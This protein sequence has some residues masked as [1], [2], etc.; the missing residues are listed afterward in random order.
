MSGAAGRR[1]RAT[2]GLGAALVMAG[3][4]SSFVSTPQPTPAPL[5]TGP[6]LVMITATGVEPQVIHVWESRRA[7]IENRD[8]RPHAL[9]SDTHPGHGE[10]GG[11]VNIGVIQPGERREISDLPYDACYFHDDSQ[12]GARAYTGVLVIH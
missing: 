1:A 4:G 12:P 6:A 10:C 9:Y 11:K 2:A 3:C 7:I 8:S 5:P